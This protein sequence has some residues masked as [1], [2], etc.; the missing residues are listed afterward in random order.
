M[1]SREFWKEKKVL[2][3]GHTGFKG[4]WLTLFLSYLDCNVIGYSKDI[5]TNPSLF[6]VANVDL[7]CKTYRNDILAFNDLLNVIH[8]E[9]PDIIFHLAAQPLVRK[10]YQFPIQ[11]LEENVLGTA[12]VLEAVRQSKAVRVLINVTS[13]K[14]YENNGAETPFTEDSPMGGHDPYSVSKGCAELITSCYLRSFFSSSHQHVS[15]A[16]AGNVIGGGDWS[17][18]RLVPDIIRSF[19]QANSLNIRYPDAVRPWQHVLDPLYGYLLLAQ[20]LWEDSELSGGWNFGPLVN[21]N[22]T[23]EQVINMS[24]NIFGTK[25]KIEYKTDPSLYEASYLKLDSSKAVQQLGWRPK[26]STKEAIIWTMDW[27]RLY[28]NGGNMRDVT[29]SQIIR[30]QEEWCKR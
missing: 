8:S 17:E 2:V 3:T 20:M 25:T 26:L 27:F 15:S 1:L 10:S 14:C 9:E 28:A 22:I 23:V 12:H 18:D 24:M 21:E 16:R 29:L 6:E 5:P 4:S 11:T 19:S 30:Y 13:D 7:D